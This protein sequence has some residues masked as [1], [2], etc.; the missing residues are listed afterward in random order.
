MYIAAQSRAPTDTNFGSENMNLNSSTFIK[1]ST[2][3][4]LCVF[5]DTVISFKIELKE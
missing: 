3:G 5:Q 1:V 4:D 2:D